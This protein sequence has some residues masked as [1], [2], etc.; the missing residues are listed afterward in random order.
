MVEL[1][2]VVCFRLDIVNELTDEVL[3][4]EIL[5]S[6]IWSWCGFIEKMD[7]GNRCS[8]RSGIQRGY[9]QSDAQV[10]VKDEGCHSQTNQVKDPVLENSKFTS[11]SV[12]MHQ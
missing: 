6:G 11:A 8:T 2:A 10:A 9:Q 7:C 12:C 3:C 4:V 1:S 5:L